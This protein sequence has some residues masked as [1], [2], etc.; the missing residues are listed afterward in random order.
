MNIETD[1]QEQAEEHSSLIDAIARAHAAASSITPP[2]PPS[3]RRQFASR[4]VLLDPLSQL[5]SVEKYLVENEILLDYIADTTVPST[6]FSS[7]SSSLALSLLA[8]RWPCF[9]LPSN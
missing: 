5:S 9:L 8:T 4:I 6:N 1:E 2:S 3:A 7:S